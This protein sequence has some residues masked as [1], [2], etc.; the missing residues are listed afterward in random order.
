MF[1]GYPQEHSGRIEAIL[2]K[3]KFIYV[4]SESFQLRNYN[5]YLRDTAFETAGQVRDSPAKLYDYFRGNLT[6][7]MH[8]REPYLNFLNLVNT[9][10]FLFIVDTRSFTRNLEGDFI[11][12]FRDNFKQSFSI[13]P[14]AIAA[15]QKIYQNT[16]TNIHFASMEE[17]FLL[18]E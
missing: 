1:F 6:R 15:K 10:V 17:E 11:R 16:L 5:A 7:T 13:V 18:G 12:Q 14:A 8:G 3:N 2:T 9:Q 4:D